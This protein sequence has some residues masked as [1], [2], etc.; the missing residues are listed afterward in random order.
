VLR[1]K[2]WLTHRQSGWIKWPHVP[3]YVGLAVVSLLEIF[4]TM[5]LFVYVLVRRPFITDGDTKT[6]AVTIWLRMNE[7]SIYFPFLEHE[8]VEKAQ[9]YCC[10]R[11]TTERSTEANRE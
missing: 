5:C 2:G 11:T 3:E 9:S 1:F 8:V 4:E 7:F 10:F 6:N